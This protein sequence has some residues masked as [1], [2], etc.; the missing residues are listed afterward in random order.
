MGAAKLSQIRTT[1]ASKEAFCA[2]W[3]NAFT[4][5]LTLTF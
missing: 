5:H 2:H 4:V 3:K 1:I